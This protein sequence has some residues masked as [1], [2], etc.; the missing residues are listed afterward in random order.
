VNETAEELVK[1]S[2]K[3]RIQALFDF[4]DIDRKGS[5]SYGGLLEMVE[6]N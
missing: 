1:G 5:I 4:Y 6:V 2:V 3:K